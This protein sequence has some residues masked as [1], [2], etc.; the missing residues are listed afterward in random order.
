MMMWSGPYHSLQDESINASL[1]QN[2][3]SDQTPVVISDRLQHVSHPDQ[4]GTTVIDTSKLNLVLHNEVNVPPYFGGDSSLYSLSE[5]EE[6]MWSYSS[7]QGYSG[8]E[9]IEEVMNRLLGETRNVTKVWL[10]S[11]PNITDVNVVYG[12]LRR[13]FGWLIFTQCSLLLGKGP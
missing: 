13:H 7:K 12:V 10:R 3:A 9:C 11:N 1:Q 2:V 5:W 6:L 8:T 4:C